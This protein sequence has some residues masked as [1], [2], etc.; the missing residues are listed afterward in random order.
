MSSIENAIK[1]A[2]FTAFA[3]ALRASPYGAVLDGG[4]AYT[5][6]AP[7][8]EAFQKFSTVSMDV[9][10]RGDEALLR[11][12]IGYHFAAGRVM[13]ASFKGRRIRAVM[14]AGG[15]LIID[16]KDGLRVNRANLVKPDVIAD[17][18]VIHGI[19]GVLWPREPAVSP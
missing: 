13:S 9:L 16:G 3:E 6:F 11:T 4:G 1:G 7:T 19:D 15:D 8:D 12:V 2:G 14:Y 18:C 10:L 5:L 17:A